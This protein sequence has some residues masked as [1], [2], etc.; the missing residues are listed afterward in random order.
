L[1]A[2]PAN[3]ANVNPTPALR[4][5]LVRQSLARPYKVTFAMIV[6]VGLVPVY[7]FIGRPGPGRLPH[8]PAIPL[9]GAI[10]LVPAWALVYGALYAALLALPLFVVREEGHLQRTVYAYISVWITAYACFL[11]YPTVA[12]RPELV[13][14]RGFSEWGLSLL[15]GMDPPYNCFPS[16]H[17]AH[18]FV[19]ALTCLRVH[20]GVGIAA[21]TGALLVALSTLFTK[22][23]YVLDVVAGVLMALVAYGIFIRPQRHAQAPELDRQVAP[24][25]AWGILVCAGLGLAGYWIA[26]KLLAAHP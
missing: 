21:S 13:E 6:L 18:S 11:V 14:V 5:E 15:Y 24:I 12:P 19:S 10:P 23:H 2:D 17:I 8:V 3:P 16:L 7:L 4:L 25:F 20:R 9:D 1:P 26:Y 22:Q